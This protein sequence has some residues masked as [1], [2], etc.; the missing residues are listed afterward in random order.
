MRYILGIDLGTTNS[1][2]CFVDTQDPKL[3]IQLFRVPQIHRLGH[4]EALET[5]PSF[6]L[7]GADGSLPWGKSLGYSVGAFAR[8]EGA[9]IPTKLVES[10]K[11]WLC[12]AAVDRRARLLPFEAADEADR[13][14]PVE[15]A[16]RYLSHLRQAWNHAKARNSDDALFE[17]QDIV[18]TVPASFDEMARALTI[19]AA[20]LAGIKQLT[21]L[22]E[23]QAAFY[24]WIVQHESSW[25]TTLKGGENIL[26][27]DVGGGTTDFSLIVVR[28]SGGELSLQRMAVGEHLLLGGDNMD[29]A[30]ARMVERRLFGTDDHDL[31]IGQ[32]LQLRQQARKAKEALLG[33]SP[34]EVFRFLLQG[35]GSHVVAKTLSAEISSGE[36]RKLLL[37]GFFPSL[38]WEEALR[39]RRSGGVKTMGLPYE[40]E[41]A[42]TKHLAHFLQASG[43]VPVQPDYVLF[44]GGAMKPGLF[45]E[46]ILDSLRRWF[47]EKEPRKLSS[48]HLDLA[49]GRG[50]AYYGRVRRGLG[51]RI[52]GGSARGY[53]LGVDICDFAGTKTTKA[54]ALLPRG[55]EEGASYEPEQVFM[56]RPNTP[57]SFTLY[58]SHVR[59]SDQPGTV[60]S[61]DPN[62]LHPLP[63][64]QTVL[65]FGKGQAT[66]QEVPVR[67]GISLSPIGT[68]DLWLQSEKTPHRWALEFQLRSSEGKERT[69]GDARTDETFDASFLDDACR[70]ISDAFSGSAKTGRLMEKL[71]EMLGTPRREWSP[72]V[73]RGLWKAAL[74]AA[75]SRK[76]SAELEARWWN[77]AGFL[78]RPGFGYPLDDYRLKELW[79][80]I[81][82]DSKAPRELEVAMQRWICLRRIAGGLSRGQ[83]AQIAA[84]LWPQLLDKTTGKIVVKG[85]GESYQYTEKLR[86]AA[87][88]ELIEPA[89]KVKLGNAVLGRIAKEEPL[90]VEL[91]ALGRLG[92][93][94]LFHGAGPNVVNRE[95][96]AGWIDKLLAQKSRSEAW[97]FAV[98][99]IARKTDQREL[100][101]SSE[102]VQRL[103]KD[104]ED[105]DK[106]GRLR[107]LLTNAT[108]LTQ[109]EQDK[110]FGEHLPAGLTLQL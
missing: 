25:K 103:L 74:A 4:V 12:H 57:V 8:E 84:E 72:S 1:C 63:P 60:I 101:L 53:Y 13:V 19:E 9:K 68:I 50:A 28:E 85:K 22:E 41:P 86:A 30:I 81:L 104:C 14:S 16:G 77:L 73:L 7:C 6:C 58:T 21:L 43:D 52:G 64:I 65:R 31:P 66:D 2:M 33:E 26:V 88:L 11:S 23:P 71:E 34:D 15:V 98:G 93:R 17:E 32:W 108:A 82:S 51:V 5:L 83:Q 95:I 47:P 105:S 87:S 89:M 49:V 96:A 76:S 100:N 99:Q 67:I 38:E 54:L 92:A 55:S 35:A 78:L 48:Y 79:K 29:I 59:L 3:S 56:L 18:L 70:E 62:E 42:V 94:H 90:A 45:Q 24:S 69:H 109:N 107:N 27:C 36:L 75:P 37:D 46:E 102:A 110:V 20:R 10:A 106:D 44:N 61:I 39:L 91:W 40:A 97:L 80:I